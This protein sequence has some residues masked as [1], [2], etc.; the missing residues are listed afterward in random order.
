M[1]LVPNLFYAISSVKRKIIVKTDKPYPSVTSESTKYDSVETVVL[2]P[3]HFSEFG[4]PLL[5]WKAWLGKT[6][7]GVSEQGS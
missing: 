4:T 2:F 7:V 6:L 3:E 1:L 5:F